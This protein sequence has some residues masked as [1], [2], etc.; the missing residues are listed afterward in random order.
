MSADQA[1]GGASNTGQNPNRGRGRGGR[2]KDQSRE[3]EGRAGGGGQFRSSGKGSN[4]HPRDWDGPHRQDRQQNRGRGRTDGAPGNR[5]GQR[6]VH[7]NA[8]RI[9]E[10]GGTNAVNTNEGNSLG[11]APPNGQQPRSDWRDSQSNHGGQNQKNGFQQKENGAKG[12]AYY[13][14]NYNNHRPPFSKN[15]RADSSHVHKAPIDRKFKSHGR[16]SLHERPTPVQ[17]V[18]LDAVPSPGLLSDL[19]RAD[20]TVP[21]TNLEEVIDRSIKFWDHFP[22]DTARLHVLRE[23]GVDAGKLQEFVR[24][25]YPIVHHTCLNLLRD[26]LDHKLRYGTNSEKRVYKG[27]DVVSFIDRLLKKRPLS[28]IGENDHYLLPGSFQE[29]YGGFEK[30]GTE[31]EDPPLILESFLSY[32]EMRLSA[33][34]S[35][36]SWSWFVNN[37]RRKNYGKEDRAG[38]YQTEGVI[39]GQVGTRLRKEGV[40]EFVDCIVTRQQ[41]RPENGF[42][43]PIAPHINAVWGKFWGCELP[44]YQD[45]TT[46]LQGQQSKDAPFE[47]T[48]VGRENIF[49]ITV[50]KKRIAI[51]AE[52][53]LCEANSRAQ[54]CGKSAYVHVVGLGL[55]VWRAFEEQEELYVEAW[56][57]A[58]KN[59]SNLDH[60]A[61]VDFSYIGCTTIHGIGNNQKFPGTEVVIRFS[62]RDLHDKV[63]DECILVCN[64]AWD[65]NSLPGNEF[66][67]GKMCST[68]DSAAACSSC[69]AEIHTH[70]I[71]PV[72]SGAAVRIATKD[73]QLLD[74]A[75][76][77]R[78]VQGQAPNLT[79][80]NQFGVTLPCNSVPSVSKP[81]VDQ[82]SRGQESQVHGT[83]ISASSSANE[84]V[85]NSE[86]NPSLANNTEHRATQIVTETPSISKET[87]P[88]TSQ[89]LVRKDGIEN[90]PCDA[91]GGAQS[92]N[93]VDLSVNNGLEDVTS[94]KEVALPSEPTVPKQI[95]HPSVIGCFIDNPEYKRQ[96]KEINKRKLQAKKQEQKAKKEESS[97]KQTNGEV[98]SPKP[99]KPENR[100]E[101]SQKESKGHKK[102]NKNKK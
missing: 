59:I 52:I 77:L 90:P 51:T 81:S 95:P 15:V 20:L 101:E 42:G 2:G 13:Q 60:V 66:W 56:G 5:N 85:W 39:V 64:Y 65:G 100:A 38:T 28:F 48:R 9:P 58:L 50:Y 94:V 69:V 25:V 44:T 72:V 54:A 10:E 53:L 40:M 35:L 26:F 16:Q 71:N 22:S 47:Y 6:F 8:G 89:D 75:E 30:I 27:M 79:L 37:G 97:E 41:N 102:K 55:G 33:L 74:V 31:N 21:S 46:C 84:I 12:D 23:S 18:C 98:K 68:G 83:Y 61:F 45:A 88:V 91:V 3:Q 93:D 70:S 24:S 62:Q 57:D 76:F 14:S 78:S 92:S 63:P 73:G 4:N 96:M 36:S 82:P 87:K 80:R 32:D 19:Q 7:G 11:H 49:N 34:V 17:P 1:T 29:G 86:C 67:M 43:T 99:K